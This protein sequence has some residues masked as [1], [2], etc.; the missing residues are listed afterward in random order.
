MT[1]DLDTVLERLKAYGGEIAMG[2][3]DAPGSRA[4]FI[5][6][7]DRALIEVLQPNA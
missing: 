5:L 1:S 7:P 4:A 3:F 2:P 6:G